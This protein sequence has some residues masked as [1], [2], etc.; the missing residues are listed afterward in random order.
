M[1]GMTACGTLLLMRGPRKIMLTASLDSVRAC[2]DVFSWFFLLPG[3]AISA[4]IVYD[5]EWEELVG[6]IWVRCVGAIG[7]GKYYYI[8]VRLHVSSF[9]TEFELGRQ[10]AWRPRCNRGGVDRSVVGIV[11]S[12]VDCG[13]VSLG[14]NHVGVIKTLVTLCSV[15][16]FLIACY[17][18]SVFGVQVRLSS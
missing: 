6:T 17:L 7:G 8:L 5:S 16:V 10:A 2:I 14:G 9:V 12:A 15:L 3:I 18:G 4:L 13:S 11:H 1:S